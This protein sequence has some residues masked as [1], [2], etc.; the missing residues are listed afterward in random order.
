MSNSI[1]CEFEFYTELC[2]AAE[3]SVDV[4]VWSDVRLH[5]CKYVHSRATVL[6]ENITVGTHACFHHY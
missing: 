6:T 2:F 3:C 5:V 4:D 1:L